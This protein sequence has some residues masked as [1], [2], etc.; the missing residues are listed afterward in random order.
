MFLPGMLAVGGGAIPVLRGSDCDWSD[1]GVTFRLDPCGGCLDGV[2]GGG[3]P[4]YF[5]SSS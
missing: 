1:P 2:F 3:A 5:C 4:P